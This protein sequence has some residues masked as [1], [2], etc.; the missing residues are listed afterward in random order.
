MPVPPVFLASCYMAKT[1]ALRHASIEARPYRSGIGRTSVALADGPGMIPVNA[2]TFAP[3]T[4]K[5]LKVMVS[6]LLP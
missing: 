2:T 1:G 5:A 6:K 3:T 4:E